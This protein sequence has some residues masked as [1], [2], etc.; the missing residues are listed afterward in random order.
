M[1]RDF[2]YFLIQN[3]DIA[4]LFWAKYV[5]VGLITDAHTSRTCS[6]GDA[7]GCFLTFLSTNSFA[8]S[9]P[10][11]G[12]PTVWHH[13]PVGK[14]ITVASTCSTSCSRWANFLGVFIND[15]PRASWTCGGRWCWAMSPDFHINHFTRWLLRLWLCY[16]DD[17]KQNCHCE[18]LMIRCHDT[19]EDVIFGKQR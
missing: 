12:V 18:I 15:L 5:L 3:H 8:S 11:H 16:R 13:G 7:L 1:M 19:Q 4:F 14:I 9:F 10:L 6:S 17:D 2:W